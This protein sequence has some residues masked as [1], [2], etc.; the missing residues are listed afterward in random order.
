MDNIKFPMTSCFKS[1][2]RCIGNAE[3]PAVCILDHD[4]RINE[5]KFQ[6]AT[7]HISKYEYSYL[8]KDSTDL[9][10]GKH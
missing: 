4:G 8:H 1:G 3:D 7:Y 9:D 2:V 10:G 5:H 6:K